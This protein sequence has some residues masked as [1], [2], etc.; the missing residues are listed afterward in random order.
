MFAAFWAADGGRISFERILAV[1]ADSICSERFSNILRVLGACDLPNVK[2]A[3]NAKPSYIEEGPTEEC[4]AD[5][6]PPGKRWRRGL[7][8]KLH[9]DR[10]DESQAQSHPEI[11]DEHPRPGRGRALDGVIIKIPKKTANVFDPL[12]EL[13]LR[14]LQKS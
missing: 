9:C 7:R 6:F 13:P 14:L 5:E 4:I 12:Q 11:S 10:A 1:R 3:R 2:N 8:E